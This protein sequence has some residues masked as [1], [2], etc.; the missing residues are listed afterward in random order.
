[1]EGC[2][3]KRQDCWHVETFRHRNRG[4]DNPSYFITDYLFA[5]NDLADRLA[6]LE[7]RNDE[8]EDWSLSDHCPPRSVRPGAVVRPKVE[9]LDT[10]SCRE[11]RRQTKRTHF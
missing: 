6:D 9:V 1:L 2:P 10:I 8:R 7:I 5:T 11:P 3:C 4:L